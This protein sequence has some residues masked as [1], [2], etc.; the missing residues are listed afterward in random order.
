MDDSGLIFSFPATIHLFAVI[1]FL[2]ASV[3]TIHTH[4]ILPTPIFIFLPSL[5][6]TNPH[7]YAHIPPRTYH[8]FSS[9]LS[10]FRS[11]NLHHLTRL[12]T[13]KP[14]VITPSIAVLCDWTELLDWPVAW[15]LARV[16][17]QTCTPVPLYVPYTLHNR[18]FAF[19]QTSFTNHLDAVVQNEID[20]SLSWIRSEQGRRSR[21]S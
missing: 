19:D 3:L 14:I 1:R 13:V 12:R 6:C 7:A 8:F 16:C 4:C 20:L 2:L 9:V 17:G 10:R 15:T 5:H 21:I 11:S 18:N